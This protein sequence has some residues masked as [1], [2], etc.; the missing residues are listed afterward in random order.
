MM[1]IH[2]GLVGALVLVLSVPGRTRSSHGS[3]YS[4]V[5]IKVT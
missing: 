1:A 3:K 4:C 2:H 5:F